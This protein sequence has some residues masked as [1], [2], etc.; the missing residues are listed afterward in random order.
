[1]GIG[2]FLELPNASASRLREIA[3][4]EGIRVRVETPESRDDAKSYPGLYIFCSLLGRIQGRWRSS[5]EVCVFWLTFP[6]SHAFIPLLWPFDF[7]LARRVEQ[8][9]LG[10]GAHRIDP[11]F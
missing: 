7:Y 1:M 10:L 4:S 8:I 9:L 2:P 5:N 3:A 6:R 11:Q